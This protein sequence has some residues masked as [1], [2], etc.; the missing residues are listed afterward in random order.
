MLRTHLIVVVGVAGLFVG[1]GC[2]SKNGGGGESP[3]AQAAAAAASGQ[4][5][6]GGGPTPSTP[7][8]VTVKSKNVKYWKARDGHYVQKNG[9]TTFVPRQ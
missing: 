4:S 3:A 2:A 5:T 6:T 7:P 9:K 8:T 1:V